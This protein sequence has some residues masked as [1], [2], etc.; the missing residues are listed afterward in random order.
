MIDYRQLGFVSDKQ[1]TICDLNGKQ[2]IEHVITRDGFNDVYSIL[3]QLRAPTHETK[4]YFYQNKNPY[5]PYSPCKKTELIVPTQ[6]T[7]TN[8]ALL[9]KRR[10]FRSFHNELQGNLL[11]TRATFLY[12]SSCTV[13]VAH[14][15][16]SDECF[17]ANA[18]ADEIYF[19]NEGQGC[20]ETVMGIMHYSKHDYIFIPKSIPYRFKPNAPSYLLIVEGNK[21]TGIPKDFRNT[22]GQ[23][24]LDAPYNHRDFTPP[25]ELLTLAENDN[26]PIIIKRFNVL[27]S[28]EHTE[29]PYNVVGWDGWYWPFIFPIKNYQPKTSNVH[30]PPS[31]HA[32]FSGAQ[33]YIMNFVPR[34]L[35]YDPKAVPCPWPHSNIDCDELLFYV[36]GDFTSRKGIGQYSM[37]FHPG[38]IPHGPHPEKYER[39]IGLRKTDELAIMVDTFE[40]LYPTEIALKFED[41]QYPSSWATKEFL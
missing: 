18:D 41:Q 22:Q 14:L 31:V 40:P 8:D 11:Q 24:K 20:V 2:L 4:S 36:H 38:G 7:K 12:N 34:L 15:T 35:D 25:K 30:L 9:P 16:T 19:V 33:F 1:H 29:F 13:G 37:S 32:M 23:L 26:P 28:H 39:S 3:Y 6:D 17:F 5:F 21:N 10:H 27:T